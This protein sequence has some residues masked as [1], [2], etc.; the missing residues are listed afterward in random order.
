MTLPPGLPDYHVHTHRCGHAG[1][2]S[3]DF[4]LKAIDRGLA[5]IAF[6]DHIPLYFLPEER[7]DIERRLFDGTLSGVISTSALE[8]GVDIGGLDVC[9]LVVEWGQTSTTAL[10]RAVKASPAVGR[11]TAGIIINKAPQ[12]VLRSA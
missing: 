12:E 5:E 7:R 3:R 4:V 11:R 1:G 10:I 8:L 2:D 6:T 9:V